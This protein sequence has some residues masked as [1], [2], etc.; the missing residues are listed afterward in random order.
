MPTRF[1]S[2]RHHLH[3]FSSLSISIAFHPESLRP[4]LHLWYLYPFWS[5]TDLLP[6]V[7]QSCSLTY[8]LECSTWP[9]MYDLSSWESYTPHA[10]APAFLGIG[11]ILTL[12]KYSGHV[13]VS[14]QWPERC[15]VFMVSGSQICFLFMGPH[16]SGLWAVDRFTI[17]IILDDCPILLWQK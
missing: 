5:W 13:P 2:A 11:F 8:P 6:S 12:V 10:C 3:T 17:P 4:L 9:W 15:P 1:D 16:P 7:P 14:K